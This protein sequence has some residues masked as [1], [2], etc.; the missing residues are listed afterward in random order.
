M[1]C[2]EGEDRPAE[3]LS[4]MTLLSG[5]PLCS[6]WP[7]KNWPRFQILLNLALKP[8]QSPRVSGC[9]KACLGK[10]R[11]QPCWRG[12]RSPEVPVAPHWGPHGH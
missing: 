3:G 5:V 6:S 4:T 10:G 11:R 12:S 2:C 9:T 8:R 7:W 1:L